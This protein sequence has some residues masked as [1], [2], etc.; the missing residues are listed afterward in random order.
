M[1]KTLIQHLIL[2]RDDIVVMDM[3]A[4]VEHLGRA[5]AGSIDKML[6]I[7]EPGS[8]SIETAGKIIS[9]GKE[10]GIQHFGIIGNKIQKVEQ[11]EWIEKQFPRELIQGM[12]SYHNIIRDTDLSQKPLIDWM[13]H[14][15]EQEFN[16]IYKSVLSTMPLTD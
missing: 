12:I 10:I 5:T 6:I 16:A 13:N 14:E 3:E 11:K 15:I 2:F 9:M 1:L 4:G 7:V 8:R